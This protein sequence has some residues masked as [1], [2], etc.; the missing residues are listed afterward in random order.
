MNFEAR[1]SKS[2]RATKI[3]ATLGSASESEEQI[4]KLVQA[5]VNMVRMNF[6]HGTHEEH[7]M[8]ITRVR[9]VEKKLSKPIGILAD[10]QGP[11]YRIGIVEEGLSLIEGNLVQFD[12]DDKI[13]N[14]ERL[15][16]PHPEIFE[17]LYPGA[18]LLMDDGKLELIV[19][20]ISNDIFSAE[21]LIGG[22]VLS[23]KGVN[24]PDIKLNTNVLTD[25]DLIDL[26]FALDNGA[27]W[28]A[29]S[30]VQSVSDVLLAKARIAGRAQLMAKIEKPAA[31]LEI[32]D[33]INASDAIMIA[34]GDLGVELDAA[35][36]P[37]VQKRLIYQC[38]KVGKPVVVATQMLESMIASPTPTR[39]EAT[40]V[41]GAVFDGADTVML[42]AETAIGE[43][44]VEV[45]ETM[46]NILISA[47]NHINYF[48]FDG[49]APLEVEPSIYHAVA[50]ASVALAQTI[51]AK[52]IIAYTASGNTAVRIARE[53]PAIRL[54]VSTPEQNVQ[55][56]LSILY[57]A[58]T[59]RQAETDY[60]KAL[61][62]TKKIL[63]KENAVAKNDAIVVVA[64]FPFGLAGS[65][66]AIR[67]E[68]I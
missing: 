15:P 37:S 36:V 39:A 66:N 25:K 41:A 51:K 1:K 14:S 50:K 46:A 60:E 42:S 22:P 5:G 58:T 62:I 11:K 65:T 18:R 61:S 35:E 44:P 59:I 8:R 68:H 19:R 20:T 49:P 23:R 38:R 45:V 57:G 29:L 28:I 30:F 16:L 48:S 31:L 6:S 4:R 24:V 17:A 26:E 34:R 53:R 52:A 9:T 64:G 32:E 12:L 63:I 7:L 47:E 33:I 2:W 21:V 55:R 56:R 40:D 10:M 13:G 54:F 27:D 43:Y 3:L 67:V